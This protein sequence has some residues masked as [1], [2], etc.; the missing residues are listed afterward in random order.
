[1]AR[2]QRA[3]VLIGAIATML[4]AIGGS[5]AHA[6]DEV[7]IGG[8]SGNWSAGSNW[9]DGTSPIGAPD[10]TLQFAPAGGEAVTTTND[11]GAS[12][13][14][15]RIRF[16]NKR[17]RVTVAGSSLVLTG[18][19][20]AIE[21]PGSGE[22][23]ITAPVALD[24]ASGVTTLVGSGSGNITL[25]MSM[26][27]SS[28][29][30]RLIISRQGASYRTQFVNFFASA[31]FGGGVTLQS[32]NLVLFSSNAL[33]A[34][35]FVVGGG[36]LQFGGT[37]NFSKAISLEGDLLITRANNTTIQGIISSA[38][39]GTGLTLRSNTM[40]GMLTL[41]AASTYNGATRIDYGP[42]S[43]LPGREVILRL[44]G[45]N[46]SV[47][48]SSLID[49]RS[50]GN[51]QVDAVPTGALNRIGDSTPIQLRGG[52][53]TLDLST[54]SVSQ[55]ET[56]GDLSV[57][58][59][60][61]VSIIPSTAAGAR[62]AS[63][64]LTRI[65]RGTV[66]F[67]GTN[68]GRT[69]SANTG[70]VFFAVAP[71]GLVGAG[72]SGLQTSILPYAIG[73]SAANGNGSGFVTYS[74]STGVRP[75]DVAT[76]YSPSLPPAAAT[77]NVRLG[78]N[79]TNNANVTINSLTLAGG[80]LNGTGSVN[81]TSGALLA[82][83]DASIA[84]SLNFGPVDGKIFTVGNL[85]LSG[86]IQGTDGLTKSGEG[87][88]TLTAASNPFTGPLTI[89]AGRIEFTATSQLGADTSAITLN[90]NQ[91]AL[92]YTGT[93]T[94][95]LSRDVTVASGVA[96]IESS[97][98]GLLEFSGDA[99]GPGGILFSTFNGSRLKLTGDSTISGP[100]F[101]LNGSEIEIDSDAALGTGELTISGTIRLA[102][103]WNTN[104]NIKV[105]SGVIDTAGFDAEWSGWLR[106]SGTVTSGETTPF[107]K[108]GEGTLTIAGPWDFRGIVTVSE[109]ALV[110]NETDT[111]TNY[112]V[113]ANG[114]LSGEGS[115]PATVAIAGTLAPGDGVGVLNTGPLTLHAGS[116][117]ELEWAS[118]ALHDSVNATGAVL[119]SGA[120]NLSL[121]LLSGFTPTQGTLLTMIQNDGTDA[122]TLINGG[123]LFYEA[124]ALEEGERFFASGSEFQISYAGGDGN[125]VTL[126]VVPEPGIGALVSGGVLAFARR[127]RSQRRPE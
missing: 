102:G 78:A 124:N 58:G 38:T 43:T 80:S 63:S 36:S 115:T 127:R 75:L 47:L 82:T 50:N 103:P 74:Q 112:T 21:V 76:E 79:V 12:F 83:V 68:L 101:V 35:P 111:T 88:L 96:V 34:G 73:D 62:L 3:I 110:L 40:N 95:A 84:N 99:S 55:I 32:G 46:G 93:G 113:S 6:A 107:E 24:S 57:G 120:V 59:Y 5:S 53:L 61:I 81:I 67:R 22:V 23:T 118:S 69:P 66:L 94:V 39:P 37:V 122:V 4:S 104:R 16:Q 125:D 123:R 70:N 116:V 89:N 42:T 105:L 31:G 92:D 28:P 64:S 10:L 71:T 7:W 13:S 30:Q 26:S 15:N 49:L 41:T 33:G 1:M 54:A 90:G 60:S 25:S 11:I 8:A 27:G 121:T 109:G 106:A 87:R 97:G 29:A 126:L 100:A 65:E 117:F 72:G 52:Q 114:T 48:D 56:A 17:G 86:Q 77:H 98:G 14:V 2:H 91:A 20:P 51:L 119:L 85:T 19:T 9:L 45:A 108:R 44:S 18:D